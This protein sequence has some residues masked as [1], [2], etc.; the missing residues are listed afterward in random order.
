MTRKNNPFIFICQ[1][2]TV[3]T[4]IVIFI[5]YTFTLTVALIHKVSTSTSRVLLMSMNTL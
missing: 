4:V 3:I 5:S 2:F 1:V